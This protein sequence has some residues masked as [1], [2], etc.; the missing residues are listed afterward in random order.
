MKGEETAA[1]Y[2]SN[3]MALHLKSDAPA[4]KYIYVHLFA[5]FFSSGLSFAEHKIKVREPDRKCVRVF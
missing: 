1:A 3:S 4:P 2:S 5:I